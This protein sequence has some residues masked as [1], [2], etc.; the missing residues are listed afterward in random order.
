MIKNIQAMRGIASLLVFAIHVLSTQPGLGADSLSW[1]YYP[2]GSAGVDIFFV[3]S[4][5]IIATVAPKSVNE[6]HPALHFGLRRAIRIYPIYWIIFVLA[7]I[8][9]QFYFVAPPQMEA[10]PLW[11]QALLLTHVNNRILAAWS[12]T[13]E[14]YFYFVVMV[15]LF[16]MPRRIDLGL[17]AWSAAM[18]II[19]F[20]PGNRPAWMWWLIFNP[21]VLE[22]IFGIVVAWLFR[23]NWMPFG[24]TAIFVGVCGL[25]IGGEA[26]RFYE[27]QMLMPWWRIA[28]FGIPAA[29]LIYGMV[30]VEKRYGWTM[31]PLWQRLGDASYALYI[32]HQ[33]VLFTLLYVWTQMGWLSSIH[34]YVTLAIWAV[35]AFSLGLASHYLIEV[36]VTRKLSDILGIRPSRVVVH[37]D[38]VVG[39]VA[40]PNPL[41]GAVDAVD[42]NLAVR[43]D[44]DPARS[45]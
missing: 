32:T 30:A 3:I 18:I 25:L 37:S 43:A 22:F 13:F 11:E 44:L 23:A 39:D 38:S 16:V 34:G 40:Q 10:R 6:P 12:L 15:I 31:H 1:Y 27:M 33:L 7:V 21:M 14:V 19:L 28:T 4:G 41:V 2:I 20:W 36:P 17:F 5:F 45:A 24:T 8:A 9:S 29:F 35:I 42:K 26:I